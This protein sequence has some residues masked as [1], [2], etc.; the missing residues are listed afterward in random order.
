MLNAI[1]TKKAAQTFKK[2]FLMQ[3]L[4]ILLYCFFIFLKEEEPIPLV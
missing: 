2:S 3:N 4:D 1:K